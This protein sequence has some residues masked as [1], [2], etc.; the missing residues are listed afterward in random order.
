MNILMISPVFD[1]GGTEIYILNLLKYYS[2][3]E[4]NLNIITSVGKRIK[5]L[6]EFHIN[7]FINN[8]MRKKTMSSLIQSTIFC[9]NVIKDKDIQV[10]HASSIYTSLISKIASKL[11]Y[12]KYRKKVRVIYTMHGGPNKNIEKQSA[13]LLNIIADKVIALSNKSKECLIKFGLN[14]NR[15]E[16]IY[17]GIEISNDIGYIGK[18][19][20]DNY[21]NV[22]NC[23]RLTEQKGQIH[24]I[25]GFKTVVE[26]NDNIRLYIVGEGELEQDLKN[27]VNRLG[28]QSYIFFLGYVDNPLE[29][30]NSMDIVILPS[31]WE[32]FPITVLEAMALSKPIIASNVNGIFEQLN[33]CGILI[34]PGSEEE[35]ARSILNLSVNG[36]FR[37]E[38]GKKA[39]NK[40]TNEFNL[41]KM[42]YKTLK[43][44]KEMVK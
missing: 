10:I 34:K 3:K 17:N 8:K 36:E 6:D 14:A 28:L 38:L 37:K 4:L 15:I 20:E 24:L 33:D 21:I 25:R 39:L 23:A 30:T 1:T 41:E 26:N 5:K 44:Y 42:G 19:K 40:Y 29:I 27:E 13:K 9:I 11:A 32:Q 2:N 43:V 16:V 31:L 12:L 35:I 7:V 22:I 18:F